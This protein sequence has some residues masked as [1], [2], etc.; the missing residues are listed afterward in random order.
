MVDLDVEE[1]HK[2]FINLSPYELLT[3]RNLRTKKYENCTSDS[4]CSSLISQTLLQLQ[5][6]KESCS[7]IIYLVVYEE[8]REILRFLSLLIEFEMKVWQKRIK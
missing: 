4:F 1:D 8:N 2:R 5:I 3:S 7:I 6:L